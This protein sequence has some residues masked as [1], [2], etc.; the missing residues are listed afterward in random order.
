V[1]DA[2]I[3]LDNNVLDITRYIEYHPGGEKI[4]ID[5]LGKDATQQF[6]DVGHSP[7][8]LDLIPRYTIGTIGLRKQNARV[9]IRDSVL[10]SFFTKEDPL[11]IHKLLGLFCLVH[12][13]VRFTMMIGGIEEGGFDTSLVS[14]LTLVPHF[15]LST[16][17]LFFHVPSRQ[18][19]T[20]MI[21]G[22]FR[23]HSII[24]ASRSLLCLAIIGWMGFSSL[25]L[26]MR[27]LIIILT[28]IAADQATQYY[29]VNEAQTTTRTLPYWEG[30]PTIVERTF[31]TYYAWAQFMATCMCLDNSMFGPFCVMLPIQLAAF[32]MTCVKKRLISARSY[33][34]IYIASLLLPH[35]IHIFVSNPVYRMIGW[36]SFGMTL[37]RIWGNVDKYVLWIG[38]I[39]L[40]N[41]VGLNP[42]YLSFIV[43]A[44]I[45]QKYFSA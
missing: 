41:V 27:S 6:N 30:C 12:F 22:E 21:W 10:R 24:F 34:L 20:P 17:S 14:F 45:A 25:G 33:H 23:A 2:W 35:V 43:L 39:A 18:N 1:R 11:N 8:A 19:L 4:L 36:I 26:I 13:F 37:L 5:V 3:V 44:F 9:K 38:Y 42:F 40:I 16:T 32:L 31:K 28:L 15:F 7:I 29:R